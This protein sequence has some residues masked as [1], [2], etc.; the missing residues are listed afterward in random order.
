MRAASKLL[1]ALLFGPLLAL[2]GAPVDAETRGIM[3]L[4]K[5]WTA[6]GGLDPIINR[7]AVRI[8][9]AFSG[10]QF[11]RRRERVYGVTAERGRQLEKELN[12]RYGG[13]KKKP[14]RVVFV[15]TRRD[16]L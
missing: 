13:R 3:N 10:T 2:S 5:R 11:F 16:R 8:L 7:R 15:P 14:I 12:K 6:A 4:P 1:I 9:V